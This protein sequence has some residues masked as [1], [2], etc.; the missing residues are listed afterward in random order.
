MGNRGGGYFHREKPLR[1]KHQTGIYSE[2]CPKQHFVRN[3][4]AKVEDTQR[5]GQAL[6]EDRHRQVQAWPVQ[7]APHPHFEGDQDQEEARSDRSRLR[8]GYREGRTDASLRVKRR[9]SRSIESFQSSRPERA[10]GQ[11]SVSA[12]GAAQALH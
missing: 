2:G 4:N 9:R 10:K 11:K 7:D 12:P 6:Q 1:P 3:L 5:R 8:S